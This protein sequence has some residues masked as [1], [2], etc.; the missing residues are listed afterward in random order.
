MELGCAAGRVIRHLNE[1]AASREIWG[2]DF[3]AAATMW[4]EENLS[5]PLHFATTTVVPHLPFK[6][7]YFDLVYAGS[8][9][10]HIDELTF[11]GLLADAS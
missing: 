6:D 3:A 9:F 2:V 8:V 10:T 11:A 5:P 4:C 1:L 7:E